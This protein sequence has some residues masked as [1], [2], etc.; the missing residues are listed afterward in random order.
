MSVCPPQAVEAGHS[1]AVL[2]GVTLS[3][4]LA[5]MAVGL[6]A[7]LASLSVTASDG[8]LQILQYPFYLAILSLAYLIFWSGLRFHAVNAAFTCTTLTRCFR[9]YHEPEVTLSELK[10]PR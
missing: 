6:K 9:R 10:L 4:L 7:A 8:L 5:A 1:W 2:L 3:Y